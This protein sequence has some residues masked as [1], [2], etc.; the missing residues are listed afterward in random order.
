MDR[1]NNPKLR[2]S[3]TELNNS[4]SMIL[5][6]SLMSAKKLLSL[7]GT[8]KAGDLVL[9]NDRLQTANEFLHQKI[10]DQ[11]NYETEVNSLHRKMFELNEKVL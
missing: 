6:S 7:N 8:I 3:Q 4:Q 5:P 11:H 1:I 9:E 2:N 10:K